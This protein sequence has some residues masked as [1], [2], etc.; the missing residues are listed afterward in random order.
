MSDIV[1]DVAERGEG[2]WNFQLI[3]FPALIKLLSEG[4]CQ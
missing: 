1:F 2:R 3:L 4:L